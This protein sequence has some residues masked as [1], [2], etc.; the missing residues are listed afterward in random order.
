MVRAPSLY[1]GG[2][3][4]E[5]MR[6]DYQIQTRYEFLSES[7]RMG[8]KD[9]ER[10]SRDVRPD[11]DAN[12]NAPR[13][14][15]SRFCPSRTAE[16][17]R[18]SM[19]ENHQLARAHFHSKPEVAS[20]G[21]S[22]PSAERRRSSDISRERILDRYQKVSVS[23]FRQRKNIDKKIIPL[24]AGLFFIFFTRYAAT[25]ASNASFSIVSFSIS[26][27]AIRSSTFLLLVMMSFARLYAPSITFLI[28]LSMICAVSSE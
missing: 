12:N 4:F 17:Y 7:L 20:I 24:L 19:A 8:T 16:R 25:S 10:K 28:S 13:R 15:D 9:S 23:F 6:A 3:W 5:S 1:L 14:A 11:C 21:A 27:F 18:R 2:S 22:P 26:T